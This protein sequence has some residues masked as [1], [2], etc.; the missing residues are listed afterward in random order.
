M[1]VAVKASA[2]QIADVRSFRGGF[3]TRDWAS[4]S[5]PAK[6]CSAE[7]KFRSLLRQSHLAQRLSDRLPDIG[8]AGMRSDKV[9]D[10]EGRLGFEDAH[11]CCLGFVE[12]SE[13]EQ[14]GGVQHM[15]QAQA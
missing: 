3:E 1:S 8:T 11:R 14:G 4:S 6:R 5:A 7:A 2:R 15:R 12:A 9:G 13:A 10:C